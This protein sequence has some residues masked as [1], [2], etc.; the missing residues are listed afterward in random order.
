MPIPKI[1]HQTWKDR[2][3]P[4]VFEDYVASWKT[5]H[6]DWEY[7]LWTDDDNRRL[8]ADDYPWFLA[9]YDRYPKPIQ[10]ADAVRYFMLHKYGGLYVDLDFLSFSSITPL[11]S[12]R[13]CVLG[14]EP[15]EHCRQFKVP[16]LVCN[17]L[18]ASV[19]KHPFF[20]TVMR[21][22]PNFVD[23]VECDQPE[24]SSTGPL[25]LTRVYEDF[26]AKD[27]MDVLPSRHFYPLTLHQAT[28]YR[29]TGRTHVDLSES[30]AVH[31]YYGNWW[32]PGWWDLQRRVGYAFAAAA[33]SCSGLINRLRSQDEP[34][35]RHGSGGL[36]TTKSGAA[37]KTTKPRRAA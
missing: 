13:E 10:R 36:P 34:R 12:G 2:D 21:E 3:V 9:T 25:M 31:L 1:L 27:T 29:L 5:N 14:V 8:I 18:M 15:P 4:R 17:A 7:R 11:L 37:D 20:E 24:L 32:K 19:P 33:R 30:V 23:H 22:L 35:R 26:A 16:Q 6:P 28:E